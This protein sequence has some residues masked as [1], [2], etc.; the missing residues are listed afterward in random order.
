MCSSWQDV[1]GH[2]WWKNLMT[3]ER[4]S[5]PKKNRFY[6]GWYYSQKV[7][8]KLHSIEKK[9]N[10]KHILEQLCWNYQNIGHPF[11]H[12][13]PLLHRLKNVHSFCRWQECSRLC[14]TYKAGLGHISLGIYLVRKLLINNCN[15]VH[16]LFFSFLF[17]ILFY[18]KNKE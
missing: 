1:V 13:P 15:I 10:F 18:Q 8:S 7:Q 3:W 14:H 6:Q 17:V 2:L 11:P 16:L 4:K 12:F 9:L 5:N